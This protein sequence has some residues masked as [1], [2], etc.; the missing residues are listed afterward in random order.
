M[1][2][3]GAWRSRLSRLSDAR[4]NLLSYYL[5]FVIVALLGVVINPI[6]LVALG[7]VAFGLLKSTQ[8]YL[9]FASVADGRSSQALKWIV[10]N[11]ST[12]VDE[13]R[14]KDIGAALVVWAIWLP[15]LLGLA[16]LVTIAIPS[17][18][19]DFPADYRPAVYL[20]ASLLAGNLVLSGLL[21]IPDSVLVGINRG[22]TSMLI[23]TI[24][25]VVANAGMVISAISGFGMPG[26]AASVLLA[27]VANGIA[28]LALAR[29]TVSWF[30]VSRPAISDV[31]RVFGF[32]AWTLLWAAVEKLYLSSELILAGLLIGAIGVTHYTFTSYV[33]QFILVIALITASGFMPS[34]G[35]LFGRG[36]VEEAASLLARVRRLV[37]VLTVALCACAIAFNGAFVSLWAGAPQYMGNETNALLGLLTLQLCLIRLDGQVLDAVLRISAK[38]GFG[39]AGALLSLVAGVLIYQTYSDFNASLIG[40]ITARLLVSLALPWLVRRSLPGFHYPWAALIM[41]AMVIGASYLLSVFLSSS[42]GSGLAALSVAAWVVL[43]S[44]YLSSV[45]E[46]RRQIGALTRKLF[47]PFFRGI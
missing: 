19:A 39:A 42:V 33:L 34:I 47:K 18:L 44:M 37:L 13:N 21:S 11:R 7:P 29:R 15:F 2:E 3:F 35:I 25:T 6:L 28:T 32:S 12:E 20:T 16:T 8:R 9:D 10:A 1:I 30:G 17:L 4:R 41:G 22:Y 23:T 43:V 38:V 26:V 46:V 36:D 24:A 27:G 45:P 40:V 14:R 31:R 5:N